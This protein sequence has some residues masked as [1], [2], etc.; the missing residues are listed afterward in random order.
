MWPCEGP[1]SHVGGVASPQPPSESGRDN[2]LGCV[3]GNVVVC[4][5]DR[6]G[7]CSVHVCT[8]DVATSPRLFLNVVHHYIRVPEQGLELVSCGHLLYSCTLVVWMWGTAWLYPIRVSGA[9]RP[10]IP[11]YV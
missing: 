9:F 11:G 1:V 6:S 4:A 5:Y 10:L 7:T 8:G 2:D 3:C